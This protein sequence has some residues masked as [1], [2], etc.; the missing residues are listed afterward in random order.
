HVGEAPQPQEKLEARRLEIGRRGSS[1][2]ARQP[3][4]RSSRLRDGRRD[5]DERELDR[6]RRAGS[7]VLADRKAAEPGGDDRLTPDGGDGMRLVAHFS[8]GAGEGASRKE[9]ARSGREGKRKE[10]AGGGGG[11]AA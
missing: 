8:R 6:P 1:R 3:Q 2:S 10:P 4:D 7:P 9:A 5:P 11:R